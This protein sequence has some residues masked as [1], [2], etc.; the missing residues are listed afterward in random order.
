MVPAPANT[1]R[2]RDPPPSDPPVLTGIQVRDSIAPFNDRAVPFGEVPVGLAKR[3]TVQFTNYSSEEI[4][5][6]SLTSAEMPFSLENDQ[7]TQAK[8]RYLQSCSLEVVF[9]PTAIGARSSTFAFNSTAV[10]ETTISV[11]LSGS[12]TP[13]STDFPAPLLIHPENNQPDMKDSVLFRWVNCRDAA[14]NLPNYRVHVGKQFPLPEAPARRVTNVLNT[15]LGLGGLLI[16]LRR[17]NGRWLLPLLLATTLFIACSEEIEDSSL[18][19]VNLLDKDTTYYW[20]VVSEYD[21]GIE[22]RSEIRTFSTR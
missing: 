1:R 15:G 3:K 16:L 4:E 6:L 20:Q 7:C 17:R 18:A 11:A 9:T 2:H 19:T 10:D 5:V 21:D 12:G 22:N 13:E 14:G 8:L